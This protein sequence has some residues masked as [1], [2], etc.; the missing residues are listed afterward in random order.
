MIHSDTP[1]QLQLVFLNDSIL[2]TRQFQAIAT[3]I[4]LTYGVIEAG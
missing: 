2:I 1:S 4:V 3:R